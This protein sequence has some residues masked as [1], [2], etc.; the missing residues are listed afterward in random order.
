MAEFDLNTTP[1]FSI[2]KNPN[3]S[4]T[5]TNLEYIENSDK[6]KFL[7]Q[8][9]DQIYS[10][11]MWLYNQLDGYEPI[12]IPFFY[13]D[14]LVIEETLMDWVV[15]GWF[16]LNNSFEFIERGFEYKRESGVENYKAPY[17]FRTDGRNRLHLK[18]SPIVKKDV[19]LASNQNPSFLEDIEEFDPE[20]WQMNFDCVIYDIEDLPT[21][22]IHDKKRKIY[23]WDEK[24]QILLEKNV[25]WSTALQ[26]LVKTGQTPRAG[27]TDAQRAINP[28]IALKSLL[29]TA[30]K[31]PPYDALG[32]GSDSIKIGFDKN[33]SIDKPN[34]EMFLID[35]LN[36]DS[37]KNDNKIF[38]TSPAQS[39]TINDMDYILG[40][41]VSNDG[42]PVF[43]RFGRYVDDKK[44]NDKNWKLISLSKYFENANK[45]QIERIIIEDGMDEQNIVGTY[46]PRG[47]VD[48]SQGNPIQNFL[49][50]VASRIRNYKF[51][52]M[53]A[54]DDL[55]ITNKPIHH[56]DYQ[57]GSFNIFFKD[58]K[59]VDVVNKLT[60]SAKKGL[61]S[62]SQKNG[63]HVLLNLN[64]TKLKGV[65]VK[66]NFVSRPFFP[67][68]LSQVQM[69]KDS[70]FLNEAISFQTQGLTIRQPGKFL[71]IDRA[72]STNNINPFDD[73]FL[74]QWMIIKVI[75][76]FTRNSYV[77]EVV[78]TKV[79]CF[80]KIWD[81]EDSKF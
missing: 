21:D 45:S 39:N 32:L 41:C 79:D 76:V 59:A 30:G 37:G 70:L 42:S 5:S 35:E 28:N 7:V 44:I 22:N 73:R 29:E 26:G 62:F 77:S 80:S 9:R 40:N 53:V 51:S 55:R 63:A 1:D 67:K 74:G 78:A 27:M 14:S 50:G 36:W 71:F 11:E 10:I 66:N 56:F 49:S 81:R 69:M 48:V 34:I 6:K 12:P 4:S 60:E 19:S 23:F 43:L 58:N 54:S 61:Y 68:N 46:L 52:P 13:I 75:H 38:Y 31:N 18:I 8:I 33:G 24:Y 65:M 20:S 17:V 72:T 15:K 25:D 57:T 64:Q 2:G 16:I 47:Y 3:T